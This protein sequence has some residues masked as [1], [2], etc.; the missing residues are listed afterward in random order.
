MYLLTEMQLA[1][2]GSRFGWT[3]AG[4]HSA[5][6]RSGSVSGRLLKLDKDVRV[7]NKNKMQKALNLIR[8]NF[9]FFGCFEAPVCKIQLFDAGFG[10][11]G[12]L[13]DK[14]KKRQTKLSICG[15]LRQFSQINCKEK[16]HLEIVIKKTT[17]MTKKISVN[18]ISMVLCIS[19][20]KSLTYTTIHLKGA[21]AVSQ[22]VCVYESECVCFNIYL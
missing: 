6:W 22:C 2:V 5:A 16:K 1:E 7:N 13:Q 18:N 19:K 10:F 21:A 3:S 14:I 20:E 4:S 15:Q 9:L 12:I 8:R 17:K 11:G